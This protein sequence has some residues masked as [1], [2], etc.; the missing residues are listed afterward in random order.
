MKFSFFL[1]S[2][3]S[4][5]LLNCAFALSKSKSPSNFIV[6][7]FTAVGLFCPLERFLV[8]L[9]PLFPESRRVET[10]GNVKL[11]EVKWLPQDQRKPGLELRILAS[12]PMVRSHLFESNFWRAIGDTLQ[13]HFN[14]KAF[15]LS[16][17]PLKHIQLFF[18]LEKKNKSSTSSKVEGK[19]QGL[20]TLFA[21][22]LLTC[23]YNWSTKLSWL[24]WTNHWFWKTYLRLTC[25][26]RDA[27]LVVKQKPHIETISFFLERKTPNLQ[28]PFH[29][30]AFKLVWKLISTSASY[31]SS[32]CL[33]RISSWTWL[34]FA[35]SYA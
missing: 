27:Y 5:S 29:S 18:Q 25:P 4:S 15:L 8:L 26:Q 30:A 33:G 35:L 17:L 31:L 23:Y 11:R 28:P 19:V 7:S 2:L 16:A 10:L 21:T 9:F 24:G 3:S 22:H 32:L 20:W 34:H 13:Q 1:N 14:W 12:S 6:F